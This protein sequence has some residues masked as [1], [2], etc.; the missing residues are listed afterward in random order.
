MNQPSR[1]DN[2]VG[3]P[4]AGVPDA[5]RNVHSTRPTFVRYFIL[6][7]VVSMSFLLYLD[8]FAISASSTALMK[9]LNLSDTDFG[10]ATSWFFYAYALCQVPSGWLSDRFGARRMLTIY[11]ALWTLSIAVMGLVQG[12]GA[13]IAM[14]CLLG[15]AQAGAYPTAASLV[16]KWIPAKNRGTANSMI[17][18]FGRGGMLVT[19]SLTPWLMQAYGSVSGQTSGLWRGVFILYGLIGFVWCVSYWYYFRD[20]PAEHSGCNDAERTLIKSWPATPAAD[21]NASSVQTLP[22]HS[23]ANI[24]DRYR[25]FC[26]I[27]NMVVLSIINVLV[28]VGWI[29]L[30]AWMPRY[31]TKVHE[32]NAVQAGVMTS[33]AVAAAMLGG[34]CGGMLTDLLSRRLGVK[35]G[36]KLPGILSGCVTALIYLLSL[37]VNNVWA[38][39]GLFALAGFFI[40][41]GLPTMWSTYQDIGGFYVATILGFCNMCGNLSA[42]F[43]AE[44]I[45]ALA[46]NDRWDTVFT[47]SAVAMLALA[48]CWMLVNASVPMK[49]LMVTDA[50]G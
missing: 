7:F 12:L 30:A 1:E 43:Y 21:A 15:M 28:N 44:T 37:Y 39:V 47:Y 26:S 31:L 29:F 18:M 10:K 24:S 45:G 49:R 19:M 8:R 17:S 20:T 25:M 3:D 13:L 34:L 40:D 4:T 50:T 48:V 27:L 16:K 42:G 5:S 32:M 41:L 46:K 14:R 11:V 33:L 35:W 22:V 23:D 36:R 2:S 38:M 6:A 9:D